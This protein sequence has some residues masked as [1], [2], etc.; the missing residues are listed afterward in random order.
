M[1]DSSDTSFDDTLQKRS[2]LEFKSHK[3]FWNRYLS[4]F[5]VQGK[6]VWKAFVQEK[7]FT[8]VPES[9]SNIINLA[10]LAIQDNDQRNREEV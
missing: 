9:L 8:N 2:L 5:Y 4:W 3:I 10:Q 7:P 1:A 6:G